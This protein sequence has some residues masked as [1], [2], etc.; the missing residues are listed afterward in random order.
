MVK[1][2]LL[3]QTFSHFCNYEETLLWTLT[4]SYITLH[5]QLS[6]AN[7]ENVA[8]KRISEGRLTIVFRNLE[9]DQVMLSKV[10]NEHDLR[11]CYDILENITSGNFRSSA[12]VGTPPSSASQPSQRTW[13]STKRKPQLPDS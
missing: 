8:G 11:R 1:I 10:G 12:M 3:S 9:W 4:T 6:A 13:G 5:P 7:I 2:F